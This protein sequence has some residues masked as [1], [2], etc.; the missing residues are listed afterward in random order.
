[1]RVLGIDPGL[2]NTGWGVIG[3]GGAK[4]RHIAHGNISTAAGD[5]GGRRLLF[6]RRALID[7]IDEYKP[8]IAG[9]E[10]IFFAKNQSS[11]IPV[12]RA[13]GVVLVTCEELGLE[14]EEFSP[15]RI[16]QAITGIGTADKNQMQELL[17]IILGIRETPKPDH[18]AD[19][20][21]AAICRYHSLTVPKGAARDV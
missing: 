11:A 4:I 12:A 1:M 20:L 10:S 13:M 14:V 15:S 9:I 5:A 6:I 8:E 16:K 3:T 17:R 18:A 2:A 21:A 19:A 7:I